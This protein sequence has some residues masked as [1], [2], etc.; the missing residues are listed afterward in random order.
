MISDKLSVQVND[1]NNFE[2]FAMAPTDGFRYVVA[3]TPPEINCADAISWTLPIGGYNYTEGQK[4]AFLESSITVPQ[5]RSLK[6]NP[7]CQLA[8]R[9]GR[10]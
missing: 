3:P 8:F 10:C 9:F 6:V 5:G 2:R 7:V 1:G 4:L